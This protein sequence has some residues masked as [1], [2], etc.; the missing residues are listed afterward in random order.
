MKYSN[1]NKDSKSNV[2]E[3]NQETDKYEKLEKIQS[4]KDKGILTEEEFSR[5]KQKILNF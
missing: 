4:L 5:E 1:K 2:S 3:K